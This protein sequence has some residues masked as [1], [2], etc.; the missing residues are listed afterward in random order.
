VAGIEGKNIVIARGNLLQ[1]R[2]RHGQ[3]MPGWPFRKT[4]HDHLA[5]SSRVDKRKERNCHYVSVDYAWRLFDENHAMFWPDVNLPPGRHLNSGRV[6]VL[7]VPH[8]GRKWSDEILR[9]RFIPRRICMRV[10]SMPSSLST[11]TP[12]GHGSSTPPSSEVPRRHG[13]LQPGDGSWPGLRRGGRRR[14]RR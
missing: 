12:S 7:P 4:K 13:L 14:P 1:P 9:H 5:I 2:Q 3:G 11:G 8:K 6:P 10:R